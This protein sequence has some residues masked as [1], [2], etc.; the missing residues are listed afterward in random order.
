VSA[1]INFHGPYEYALRH[2]P[3]GTVE[4]HRAEY[5][6]FEF[7]DP[8]GNDV[9]FYFDTREQVDG[10][11]KAALAFRDMFSGATPPPPATHCPICGGK[12]DGNGEH[13][14]RSGVTIPAAEVAQ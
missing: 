13:V 9:T 6:S 5:G 14:T 11:I 12:L 8:K 1:T 10:L 7:K 2:Y 4:H 3:P